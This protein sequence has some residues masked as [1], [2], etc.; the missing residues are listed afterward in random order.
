MSCFFGG[1]VSLPRG[2]LCLPA[3][4]LAVSR[5]VISVYA[6]YMEQAGLSFLVFRWFFHFI[7]PLHWYDSRQSFLFFPECIWP[8][9]SSVP[10]ITG[11]L[12][13]RM[14][15]EWVCSFCGASMVTSWNSYGETVFVFPPCGRDLSRSDEPIDHQI[16]RIMYRLML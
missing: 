10:L 9:G 1:E 14:G 8:G 6:W 3:L 11:S 4:L 15:I 2:F 7:F 16:S 5:I 13:P 12:I